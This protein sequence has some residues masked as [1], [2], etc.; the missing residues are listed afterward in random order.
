MRTLV[1]AAI[2]VTLTLPILPFTPSLA[3]HDGYYHG[4]TWRDSQGRYRCRRANGTVGIIVGGEQKGSVGQADSSA[5]HG[6]ETADGSTE[7]DRASRDVR[8]SKRRCR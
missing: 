1:I 5:N 3:N 4:K 7:S 2:T 6:A 8:K